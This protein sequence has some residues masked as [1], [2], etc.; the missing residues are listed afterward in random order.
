MKQEVRKMLTKKQIRQLWA[1]DPSTACA[2]N[3]CRGLCEQYPF[4]TK[5]AQAN[6]RKVLD[7]LLEFYSYEQTI[8]AELA[9]MYKTTQNNMRHGRVNPDD[10]CDWEWEPLKRRQAAE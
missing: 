6:A 3:F 2:L 7:A 5:R 10:D 9:E 8:S 1:S 4:F